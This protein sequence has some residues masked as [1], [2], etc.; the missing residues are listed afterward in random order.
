MTIAV[1][2]VSKTYRSARGEAITGL[3][4]VSL[5][6][7]DGA[8]VSVVGRSGCGKST[9]L[10]L[11]AGLESPSS[12]VA[13][14]SNDQ[15][16][17]P[18]ASVRYLF[19]NFS[20]SLLPWKTVGANIRFGLRHAYGSRPGSADFPGLVEE[21]LAEVGLAGISERYPAELSGG[22]QQ[23]V[24]IAR[25]LASNPKVL[26]LDEPFSAVDALSRATLQDLLLKV[27]KDH[28]LTVVFVTHDIEEALYLSDRV[29]VLAPNG[30]GV[31]LDVPVDLPRPRHQIETRSQPAFLDLRRELLGRV[32][33]N[34]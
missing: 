27:W 7:A 13:T 19:Q 26:L 25:A 14:I 2:A 17:R 34:Q 29:I 12:G 1:S 22:M 32:L 8:F 16:S 6:I 30:G 4:P 23:R 18:P 31:Q 10:R 20:E 9:L 28:H 15:I 3:S 21:K 11:L 5:T 24:A 33:S